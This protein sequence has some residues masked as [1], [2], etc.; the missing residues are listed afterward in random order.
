MFGV[1]EG[2]GGDAGVFVGVEEAALVFDVEDDSVFGGVALEVA[3]GEGVVGFLVD[4]DGEGW[5]DVVGGYLGEDLFAQ[6]V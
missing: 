1:E 4:A 3:K 5:I 6:S 2:V